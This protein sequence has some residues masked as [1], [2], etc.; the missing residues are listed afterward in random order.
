MKVL[1]YSAKDLEI[2]YLEDANRK[3]HKL[4][5]LKESLSSKTVMKSVGYDAISVFSAD[6][7]SFMTMEKLKDFGVKYMALRSTG[8]DNV[9]LN[10]AARLNIKVAN[11][12]DYSPNAIAEHAVALLLAL[13]RKLI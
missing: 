11:V 8:Y 7:G 5:F 10:A 13:N 6:D 1:V 12:P 9:N 2:P 4:T 3:K